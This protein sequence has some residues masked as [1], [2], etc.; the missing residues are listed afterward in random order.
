MG[1]SIIRVTANVIISIFISNEKDI[2]KIIVDV[3]NSSEIR[4]RGRNN[5][6]FPQKN[7]PKGCYTTTKEYKREFK[8]S[9]TTHYKKGRKS[10]GIVIAYGYI[11]PVSRNPNPFLVLK[12]DDEFN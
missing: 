3:E 6:I 1:I 11:I 8:V 10:N 4:D 2:S 5:P 12:L 9:K 7:T